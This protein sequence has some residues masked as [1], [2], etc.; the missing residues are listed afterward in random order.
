MVRAGKGIGLMGGRVL[1]LLLIW[2]CPVDLTLAQEATLF[3]ARVPVERQD[4]ASRVSGQRRA[5][6]Q[7]FVKVSGTVSIASHPSVRT[8]LQQAES[9]VTRFGFLR[10]PAPGQT[11]LQ[12]FLEASFDSARVLRLLRS[13]DLPVWTARRPR[14]LAW[15]ALSDAQGER[16]LDAASEDFAVAVLLEQAE[17]RGIPVL[18]PVMDMLDIEY[19]DSATVLKNLEGSLQ[20]ATKRYGTEGMMTLG[21]VEGSDGWLV[22]WSLFWNN[23]VFSEKIPHRDLEKALRESI[24]LLAGR[25]ALDYIDLG[26]TEVGAVGE[27]KTQW[28]QVNKVHNLKIYHEVVKFLSETRG[29]SDVQLVR[30]SNESML[31]SIQSG[32][33]REHLLRFFQLNYRLQPLAS[34]DP[35]VIRLFWNG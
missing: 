6:E 2:L 10:R 19:V 7:V 34:T 27:V 16:V 18:L 20:L 33:S 4:V 21:L 30:V 3:T 22:Q 14:I 32:L 23:K 8:A 28:I 15:V 31:F 13:A 9:F 25:L 29:I 24:D 11:E 17:I 12:L 35:L 5:L 1:W 26:S